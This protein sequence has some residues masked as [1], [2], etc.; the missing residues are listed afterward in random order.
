[1]GSL[2]RK[3]MAFDCATGEAVWEAEVKGRVRTTPVIWK[4]VLVVGTEARRVYGFIPE[5]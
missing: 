4:G 1:M 2:N 5:K 3:I